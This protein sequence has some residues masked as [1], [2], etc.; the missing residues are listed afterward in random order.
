[1]ALLF[2]DGFD[3]MD[4][5]NGVL[6]K[7]DYTTGA[8][9][10]YYLDGSGRT[11]GWGFSIYRNDHYIQKNFTGQ[12]ST[13]I[14]GA[15]RK[16]GFGYNRNHF[17][18]IDGTTVQAYL[19]FA[20]DGTITAY[21]GGSLRGTSSTGIWVEHIW[22]YIEFKVKFSNTVGTLEVRV[23]GVTVISATGI[24]T[25]ASGNEY[26]TGFRLVGDVDSAHT[27]YDDCYCC[28]DSGTTNNDFLGDIKITTLYPI[29]DGNSSDF[30][31]S[32][33]TDHFA[34][35]DDPQLLDSDTDHNESSTVGH[36]DLYGMTTYDGP[37]TIFG[38]QVVAAVKNTDVGTMTVRPLS[39]SGAAPVDNEGGDYILSQIM[40]ASMHMFEEEPADSV[41]W[42]A[43]KINA[44]EFGLKI[45]S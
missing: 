45:Q 8:G 10:M 3:H 19:K 15:A 27:Y 40:R 28:D 1:M 17:Q 6:A 35:V 31:C 32:T 36:K 13:L 38:V 16:S 37:D 11:G 44:A 33:G 14:V 30:T 26:G 21:A 2:V 23:D 9:Y 43:A 12:Y 24:D 5:A 22:Q 34:L 25:S 7:W 42:T 18:L 4:D 20:V 29:S 39:R 41:G